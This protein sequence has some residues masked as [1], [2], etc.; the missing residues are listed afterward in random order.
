MPLSYRL[1]RINHAQS[2]ARLR[3]CGRPDSHVPQERAFGETRDAA[4]SPRVRSPATPDTAGP[5]SPRA[6]ERA[7]GTRFAYCCRT[8][9]AYSDPSAARATMVLLPSAPL[10]RT[11]TAVNP[12]TRVMLPRKELLSRH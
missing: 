4:L 5:L 11:Y 9:T 1:S 10:L 6:A 3:R 2:N 8:I 7:H 12:D